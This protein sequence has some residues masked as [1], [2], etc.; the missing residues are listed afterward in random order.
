MQRN[1]CTSAQIIII[2]IRRL[3]VVNIQ[4]CDL[5]FCHHCWSEKFQSLLMQAKV[6]HIAAFS[7]YMMNVF[8]LERAIQ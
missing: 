7:G 8:L 2:I 3:L 5:P 6:A 1:N 4:W